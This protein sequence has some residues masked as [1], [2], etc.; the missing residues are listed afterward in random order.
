MTILIF[1]RRRAGEMRN[2]TI[3]EFRERELVADQPDMIS[4]AIS[5]EMKNQIK[6][7]MQIRGKLDRDVP[8]LLKHSWE[9]SIELLIRCRADVGIPEDNDFLF[10]LPTQSQNCK[11]VGSN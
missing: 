1:N 6:S 3:T 11:C 8:V 9:D 4:E 2:I 10:A 7:R 5:E